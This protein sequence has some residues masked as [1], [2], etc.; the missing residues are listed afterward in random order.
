MGAYLTPEG[1]VAVQL[2]NKT[3]AASIKGTLVCPSITTNHAIRLTENDDIDP[4]GVIYQDGCPDGSDV[5][6][7]VSGI[8]D[9]LLQDGTAATRTYWARTSITQAGRA[10]VSNAAPAGGTITALENHF[11]E[12]GH[13]LETVI[14]GTNK[15]C[16]MFLHFN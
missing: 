13:S 10:D 3:G 14:S 6:V 4:C 11:K 16:R 9:V 5:W 2:I 15:L 1:G 7:V 8:A 12:V